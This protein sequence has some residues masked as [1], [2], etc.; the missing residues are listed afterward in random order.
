MADSNWETRHLIERQCVSCEF[1]TEEP[2][3][4]TRLLLQNMQPALSAA[5]NGPSI[6]VILTHTH[7]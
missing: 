5:F 1:W 4:L 6:C 3:L 7:R 2:L